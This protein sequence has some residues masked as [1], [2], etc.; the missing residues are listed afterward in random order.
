MSAPEARASASPGSVTPCLG[1]EPE[2]GAR[3]ERQGNRACERRRV[4]GHRVDGASPTQRVEPPGDARGQHRSGS[5]G[6]RLR[7]ARSRE[8]HQADERHPEARPL[9]RARP[10]AGAEPRAD[11]REL[12]GREQ[13]QGAGPRRDP[14]VGEREQ[15]RVGEEDHGRGPRGRR[16]RAPRPARP[17]QERQRHGAADEP[18]RR[19]AGGVCVVAR[20]RRPAQERVGGEGEHRRGGER[21]GQGGAGQVRARRGVRRLSRQRAPSCSRRPCPRG[22]RRRP[23]GARS[24]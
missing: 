10:L 20:E 23:G 15:D 24:S 8:Q 1:D 18:Q 12:D 2:A 17:R 13:Q 21:R 9:E 5:G 16:S 11:H 7:E 14:Q 19:E 4:R 6:V 22:P 3:G